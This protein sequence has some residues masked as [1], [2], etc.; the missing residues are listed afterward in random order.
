MELSD[1]QYDELLENISDKE[2]EQWMSWTK[3]L[4]KKSDHEIPDELEEK[5]ERNWL[6]YEE[7]PEDE[8]EKD[9]KWARKVLSELDK[10]D[11]DR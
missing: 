4:V 5:W 8:K 2:H 9:R 7:L 10:L 1:D 6:P 3:W 11:S